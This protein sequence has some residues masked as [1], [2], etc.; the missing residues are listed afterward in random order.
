M[1]SQ[2]M[3]L[4]DWDETITVGDTIHLVAE[5]A[6]DA[7][8]TYSASPSG[9]PPWSDFSNAYMADY[10]AYQSSFGPRTSLEKELEF[11]TSSARIEQESVSRIEKAGLFK[12][13]T[14]KHLQL[15]AAKVE[16]RPGFINVIRRCRSLGVMFGIFSVNWSQIFIRSALEQQ[17]GAFDDVPVYC[18]EIEF[19]NEGKGT[20]ILSRS[21][22]VLRTGADKAML[23]K[24]F[25]ARNSG[26]KTVYV[27]DSTGDLHPLLDADVGVIMGGKKSL[28]ETCERVGIT[29]KDISLLDVMSPKDGRVLYCIREWNELLLH[30]PFADK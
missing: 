12:S 21:E 7:H 8:G 27:G 10:T 1:P 24:Q 6:Y 15:Q 23:V 20:G 25:L 22:Y 29:I 17:Y 9:V 26:K 19:D 5:A 18:N 13:V 3:L 2:Y 30:G 28:R 16:M 4:M 11:L 14:A